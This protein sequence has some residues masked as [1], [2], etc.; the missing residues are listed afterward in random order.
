MPSKI[1]AQGRWLI[2]E[3][4]SYIDSGGN[5]R[6]WECVRRVAGRGAASI[7]AITRISGDPHLVVVK[8]FRPPVN[9]YVIELPAGLIDM[10][11]QTAMTAARE[12]AE[13][14]GFHGET[15][16]VGPFVHNSPGLSD[17]KVAVVEITVSGRVA[18]TAAPGEIQE[19]MTLPLKDLKNTL[20]VEEKK[21]ASLDAKLWC[22]TL[23]LEYRDSR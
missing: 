2:L 9:R 4:I 20:L 19:V 7:I 14:T 17:E 3:E 10:G 15:I 5:T 8:Q 16:G 1:L 21:G 22:F 13:E 23:G 18:P 6:S 12:L 11:E